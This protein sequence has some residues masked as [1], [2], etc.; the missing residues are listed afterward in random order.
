MSEAF[1]ELISGIQVAS[2]NNYGYCLV[3]PMKIL[4]RKKNLLESMKRHRVDGIIMSRPKL[5]FT[6][7]SY[8]KTQRHRAHGF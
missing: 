2:E 5:T 6:L 4:K 1:P 8:A 3:N 7:R